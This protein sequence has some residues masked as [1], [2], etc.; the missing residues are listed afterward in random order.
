MWVG[1]L[2]IL[3]SLSFWDLKIKEAEGLPSASQGPC[4]MSKSCQFLACWS[5]MNW[6]L[7]GENGM[8]LASKA[9]VSG[10]WAESPFLS[11]RSQVLVRD[12]PM[13]TKCN[14]TMATLTSAGIHRHCGQTYWGDARTECLESSA[15]LSLKRSLA[16]AF[17]FTLCVFLAGM[18]VSRDKITWLVYWCA[19]PRVQKVLGRELATVRRMCEHYFSLRYLFRNF[20]DEF[21]WIRILVL[22]EVRRL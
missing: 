5:T 20:T 19:C 9:P 6:G 18:W 14:I 15:A 7:A 22:K 21:T 1:S 11:P 10:F 12:K 8:M 16:A 17:L 4:H 13:V 3:L 2:L